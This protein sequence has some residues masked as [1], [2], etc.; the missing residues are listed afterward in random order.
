MAQARIKITGSILGI[1][2]GDFVLTLPEYVDDAPIGYRQLIDLTTGANTITIP[3][4][5]SA[6]IIIPPTTNTQALT[7]KGVSGDTGISIHK[8]SPTYVPFGTTPAN[9]V[10]TSGGTVTG[11]AFIFV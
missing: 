5:A 10:V 11:C 9:F 3:T 8:T 6:V 2:G 4:G 1:A 7:L